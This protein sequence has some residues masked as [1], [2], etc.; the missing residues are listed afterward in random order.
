MDKIK[1]VLVVDDEKMILESVSAYLKKKGY[2]VLTAENG[3]DALSI[4]SEN[5]VI[6]VIL[7]LMLPGMTGE[8]VCREIRKISRVPIIMLTAKHSEESILNGLQIGA[9]DY[10]TKP[11]SIKELYARM[12][13]VLRRSSD[14]IKSLSKKNIWN[15]DLSID[16]DLPE[17]KKSGEI[18]SLTPSEWKILAA[19]SKYPKK[20][21]SRDEL[22][23]LVFG[24]EF[25]GYDRVIDTHVKNLR[26]KIETDPKSPVYI[27]T[28]HGLGYKFGGEQE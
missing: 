28:V 12:E 2:N 11:F 23:G 19:L 8:E 27:K 9:D 21:Y 4:L 14:E 20:I 25:D 17:V 6:F 26:K 13:A 15:K 16:Y 24:D 18:V 22:I 1:N 10:I 5:A 7:D 3:K